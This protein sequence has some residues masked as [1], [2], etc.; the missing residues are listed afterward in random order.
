MTYKFT[1]T[2]EEIDGRAVH[3]HLKSGAWEMA[4]ETEEGQG[5]TLVVFDEEGEKRTLEKI[6]KRQEVAET[7]N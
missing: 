1:D 3:G 7:V 2:G 4:E 6:S 5:E